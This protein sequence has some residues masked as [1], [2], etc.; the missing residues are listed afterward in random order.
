MR[1]AET[2]LIWLGKRTK[3]NEKMKK[4]KN[5]NRICIE[6][7]MTLGIGGMLTPIPHK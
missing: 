3:K 7:R 1:G 6:V 2:V 4:S 5:Q